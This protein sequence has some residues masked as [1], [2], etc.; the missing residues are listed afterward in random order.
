MKLPSKKKTSLSVLS[1]IKNIRSKNSKKFWGGIIIFFL[2]VGGGFIRWYHTSQNSEAAF[3]E[4]EIITAQKI[5]LRRMVSSDGT[6]I[7]PNIVN[8]SFLVNGT[9]EKIYFEEGDKVKA[10]DIL[11]ELDK[12]EFR[13]DLQSAENDV[14]ISRAHI[15]SKEAELTDTEL[16]VA[17]NDFFSSQQN[18]EATKR[19]VE[20]KVEQAFD[21]TLVEIETTI[22]EIEE[23]LQEIDRIM[24]V[25]KYYNTGGVL[26]RYSF[27]DSL[28]ERNAHN[29]YEALRREFDQFHS[30]YENNHA[31]FE[32]ADISRTLW[33]L[34]D[35]TRSAQ[36]LLD[37]M[38]SLLK[39]A[40]PNNGISADDIRSAQSTIESQHSQITSQISSL[41]NA[42]QAIDSALLARQNNI[43]EAHN[44]LRNS[45]IKFENSEK[46][47]EK[48]EI[49][50]EADLS[51]LYAQLQQSQLKVEK[52]KYNL[53]LTALRSP[54]NGEIIQINGSE[55]ETIKVESTSSDNAFI[56]ILSDSNFTTEVYVEEV[57]IAKISFGQKVIITLDAVEDLE[58]EGTVSF[59]SSTANTESNNGIVTYL[60]RVDITDSKGAPIREGMT[61]YVDFVIGEALDVVAVPEGAVYREKFVLMADG[62]RR[63]V[64][65]GFS[66]GDMVEIT[67]G[68][69]A[70]EKILLGGNVGEKNNGKSSG[71][72][73]AG[74]QEMSTERI[75]QLKTAGFTEAEIQQLQKGEFTDAIREKMRAMREQG[76]GNSLL[77]T[78]GGRR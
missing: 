61:T 4:P 66:D 54:I 44:N 38:I 47:Y 51:V 43:T 63:E 16:R 3:S 20:Q 39:S 8:L 23:A 22:P 67:S 34:T 12:R 72:N 21:S 53:D 19:D 27:N 40:R 77:P 64:E 1:E 68:L 74:S 10:G 52:A 73:R 71:M 26:V 32:Q 69:Q 11:A 57:D 60:V 55:G 59:I 15:A 56:K 28:Q 18:Y 37:I 9:L 49:N 14:R 29:G 50:K 7:N 6:I 46:N 35:M 24:G 17:K 70:G 31:D 41:T 2:V 25:E 45:E 13:F 78:R 36:T 5:N 65:I 48:M 42:K 33:K 30:E 58:L 76:E 75:E 62:S